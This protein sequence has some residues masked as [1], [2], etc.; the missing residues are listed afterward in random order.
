MDPSREQAD[1]LKCYREGWCSKG[2]RDTETETET[3][4]HKD[5]EIQR[6]RDRQTAPRSQ[7]SL[8]SK[9]ADNGFSLRAFKS[10]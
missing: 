7:H 2:E 6:W 4:R 8:E 9:Q 5:R 10:H 1:A 3:Y